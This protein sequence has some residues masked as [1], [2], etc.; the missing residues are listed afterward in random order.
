MFHMQNLKTQTGEQT[1]QNKTKQKL[2]HIERDWGRELGETGE[3][4]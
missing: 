2:T 3:R 4:D 1:K